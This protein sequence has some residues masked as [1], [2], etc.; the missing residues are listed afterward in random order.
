MENSLRYVK[1]LPVVLK[2]LPYTFALPFGQ[3]FS[4]LFGQCPL[5]QGVWNI[6]APSLLRWQRPCHRQ[7]RYQSNVEALMSKTSG[8]FIY[9]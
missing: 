1:L 4:I 7:V 2:L 9:F 5:V 3:R 6:L 8:L